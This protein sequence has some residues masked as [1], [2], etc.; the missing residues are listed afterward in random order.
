MARLA[1]VEK[2]GFYPTPDEETQLICSRLCSENGSMINALDPCCGE[3]VALQKMADALRRIDG[4]EVKSYGVE[5]EDGRATAASKVLDRAIC[6]DYQDAIVTPLAFSF[7]FLNPPYET[8][9]DKRAEIVF[10]QDL[11]DAYAGRIQP[12]GLMAYVI[13]EHVLKDAAALL[14]ARFRDIVVYRFTKKNYPIYK[15]IVVFGYRCGERPSLDTYKRNME[16]LRTL[17]VFEHIP[18]I[19]AK[20]SITFTVP[21]SKKEVLTFKPAK[22][23]REEIASAIT[24]SSLWRKAGDILPRLKTI[25][26]MKP[27]VLPLKPAHIAVAI[28]AGA[29]GG[30]MGDHI[31]VGKTE[32]VVDVK[33]IPD[34]KGVTETRT[35]RIVTTARVFARSGVYDLETAK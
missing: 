25:E 34:E 6:S 16:W 1:S 12:D 10:L 13:P 7:L 2:A 35:E 26:D 14:A 18:P 27:P 33:V 15:Q 4:V 32:K 31:L 24:R 17:G 19:D 22:P 29:V 11:T 23:A 28:A 3:G 5:L 20:D 9:G 8:F 21:A 30:S